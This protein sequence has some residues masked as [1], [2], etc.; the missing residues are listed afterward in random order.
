MP[1]FKPKSNKK[2]KFNKKTSITLDIKHNEFLNEFTKDENNTIPELKFEIQEL[3]QKLND[4]SH[5]FTVEQK[6]DIGDR[7]SELSQKIKETKSKKKEYLL[8]N[9]KFIFP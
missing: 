5:E 9:S 6:L 3:K 7:I 2:I 4:N 1:N 8:D